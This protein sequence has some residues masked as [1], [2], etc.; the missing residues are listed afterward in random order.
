MLAFFMPSFGRG[1]GGVSVTTTA[2]SWQL[3]PMQIWTNA[4]HGFRSL[5][6]AQGHSTQE[7]LLPCLD[8]CKVYG[9]N[10]S[11]GS[12]RRRLFA[13]KGGSNAKGKRVMRAIKIPVSERSLRLRRVLGLGC[14]DVAFPA[15][16]AFVRLPRQSVVD[17]MLLSC[18]WMFKFQRFMTAGTEPGIHADLPWPRSKFVLPVARPALA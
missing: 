17:S 7:G 18:M 2:D 14:P 8:S 5:A 1:G 6:L 12:N 10:L 3:T 11:S 15:A 4:C 13:Y 9:R 16:A